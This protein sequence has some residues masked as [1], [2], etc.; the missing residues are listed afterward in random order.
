MSVSRGQ[1]ENIINFSKDR[2]T[3]VYR[4]Q[5]K[6]KRRIEKKGR[7]E[8]NIAKGEKVEEARPP[9]DEGRTS[10]GSKSRG[11]EKKVTSLDGETTP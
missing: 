3:I 8:A 4:S 1:K 6:N 5:K 9:D 11:G 10:R 2:V 7:R